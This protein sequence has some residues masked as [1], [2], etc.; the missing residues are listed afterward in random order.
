[1]SSPS[2]K[3]V[4]FL[5]VRFGLRRFCVSDTQSTQTM[6]SKEQTVNSSQVIN[7]LTCFRTRNVN[8]VARFGNL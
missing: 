3:R 7:K 2:E 4:S 5:K 8:S 6:S 1:M